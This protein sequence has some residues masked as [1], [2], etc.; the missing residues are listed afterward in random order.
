VLL[1]AVGD[2]KERNAVEVHLLDAGIGVEDGVEQ[3]VAALVRGERGAGAGQEFPDRSSP[4]HS[5][6]GFLLLCGNVSS[7]AGE[8]NR[9]HARQ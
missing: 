6:R 4:I 2:R 1:G 8:R 5:R 3:Q 9:K 7:E